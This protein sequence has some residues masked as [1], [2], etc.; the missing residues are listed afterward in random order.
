MGQESVAILALR[1]NDPI[2]SFYKNQPGKYFTDV[3]AAYMEPQN[4]I[5]GY[6][7]LI[8]AAMSGKLNTSHFP[9]QLKIIETLERDGLLH[10]GE[11]GSVRVAGRRRERLG[12]AIVSEGLA[13]LSRLSWGKEQSEIG[14]CQWPLKAYILVQSIFMVERTIFLLN[15]NMLL[16]LGGPQSLLCKIEPTTLAHCIHL[17]LEF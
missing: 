11:N 12:E 6:Y 4:E 5:V 9:Q 1:E 2:S 10:I 8:A 3:D 14:P 13:I 17:C 15:S 7:Q 16:A